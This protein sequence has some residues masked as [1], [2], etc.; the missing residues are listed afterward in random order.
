MCSASPPL[1]AWLFYAPLCLASVY[2]ESWFT[3]SCW[4]L[5][6]VAGILLTLLFGK[7]VPVK[8]PAV[9][10]L[11]WRD[12]PAHVP[13]REMEGRQMISA[14]VR[15]DRSLGHPLGNR[16]MMQLCGNHLS[17]LERVSA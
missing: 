5:T 12:L 3:A 15:F 7:P 9:V 14:L 17:T 8:K 2:G 11:I 10:L 1:W 6:I 4:Q 16:K 13:S